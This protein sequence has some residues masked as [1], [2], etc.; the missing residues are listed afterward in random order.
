MTIETPNWNVD[1]FGEK[2]GS[3]FYNRDKRENNNAYTPIEGETLSGYC[4]R[5]ATLIQKLEEINLNAHTGRA[6]TKM[7]FTHRTPSACWICDQL[8]VMWFLYET[9]TLMS[10]THPNLIFTNK[11]GKLLLESI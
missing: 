4:R 8:N 11:E 6:G 1:K 5:M 10:N 2:Q 3:T 9:M 7:W